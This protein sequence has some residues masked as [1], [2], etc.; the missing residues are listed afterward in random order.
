MADG[1]PHYA[2]MSLITFAPSTPVN[3]ALSVAL[4]ARFGLIG[5]VLGSVTAQLTCV[6][7]PLYFLRRRTL[8]VVFPEGT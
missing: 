1:R 7:L 4:T 2:M 3:F 5:P 6:L 8:A